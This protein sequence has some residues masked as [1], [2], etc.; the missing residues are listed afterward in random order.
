MSQVVI[1]GTA[2][3]SR[4]RLQA[5]PGCRR[6]VVLDHCAVTDS[7]GAMVDLDRVQLAQR[8]HLAS[9]TG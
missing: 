6:P 5:C 1:T 2:T 9:C 7:E 3:G 4:V 8:L